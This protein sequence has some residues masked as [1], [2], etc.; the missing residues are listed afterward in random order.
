MSKTLASF[1]E[2][3]NVL[4]TRAVAAVAAA[5]AALTEGAQLVKKTAQEKIGEYQPAAGDLPAWAPLSPVTQADRVAKGFS[6]D[7][8]LLR[9]GALRDSIEIRPVTE[10]DVLV[11][12]F[13]PEMETIAGAMEYGYYNVR[14]Q[15]PVPPRSFIRGSAFELARPIGESIGK[16]YKDTLE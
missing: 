14:A 11:G 8:P 2:L 3:A 9:T 13:D 5:R 6:P 7:N 1:S 4:E 12:V 15:T 10:D 16:A